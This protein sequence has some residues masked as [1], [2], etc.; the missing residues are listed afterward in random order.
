MRSRFASTCLSLILMIIAAPAFSH[1]GHTNVIHNH[2]GIE[3]FLVLFVIAA[4]IYHH[5]KH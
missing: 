3:Y 2:S 5:F 1:P 4:I